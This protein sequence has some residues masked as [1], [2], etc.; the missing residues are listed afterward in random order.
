MLL[1]NAYNVFFRQSAVAKTEVRMGGG[2]HLVCSE[3]NF[4]RRSFGHLCPEVLCR[5]HLCPRASI[6]G[7]RRPQQVG[8]GH[9]CPEQQVLFLISIYCVITSNAEETYA[10][11]QGNI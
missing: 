4:Y 3:W 8:S 9:R 1:C 11:L 7:R 5:G 6:R 2:V 10:E